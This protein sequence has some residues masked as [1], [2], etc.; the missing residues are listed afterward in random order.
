MKFLAGYYWPATE[1]KHLAT[2]IIVFSYWQLQIFF[3][4]I[5]EEEEFIFPKGYWKSTVDPRYLELLRETKTF[6]TCRGVRDSR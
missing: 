6:S 5:I 3:Q 2:R 4:R 1:N